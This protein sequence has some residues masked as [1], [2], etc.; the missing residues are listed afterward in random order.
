VKFPKESFKKYESDIILHFFS[1]QTRTENLLQRMSPENQA[2]IK[3]LIS[4]Y[5]SSLTSQESNSEESIS[6][7]QCYQCLNVEPGA[8]EQ[9][10]NKAFRALARLLHTDKAQV[11]AFKTPREEALKRIFTLFKKP[12]PTNFSESDCK[13]ALE[14]VSASRVYLTNPPPQ[15]T[16]LFGSWFTTTKPLLLES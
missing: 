2:F 16:S 13:W 6:R 15:W 12:I 3:P 1:D 7:D 5:S 9:E 10:V 4:K 14:K 11:L 8:E